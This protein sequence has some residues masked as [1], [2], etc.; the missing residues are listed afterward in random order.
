MLEDRERFHEW[1]NAGHT[2]TPLGR[3]TWMGRAQRLSGRSS[4]LDSTRMADGRWGIGILFSPARGGG[5]D[6]GYDIQREA[7]GTGGHGRRHGET[8][9]RRGVV[10][11]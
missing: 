2:W 9:G 11:R 10:C 4:S 8:D 1:C 6:G 5:D 3:F 7:S